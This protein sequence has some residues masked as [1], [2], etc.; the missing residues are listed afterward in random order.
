[1]CVSHTSSLATVRY[2]HRFPHTRIHKR[3]RARI[4]I[5]TWQG[6]DRQMMR[7]RGVAMRL[8]RPHDAFPR[9]HFLSGLNGLFVLT[10]FVFHKNR[11]DAYYLLCVVKACRLGLIVCETEKR[12]SR[13]FLFYSAGV[14][15]SRLY[16]V[17][18]FFFFRHSV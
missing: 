6:T 12:E 9:S 10:H 1:M 4:N 16:V 14:L 5:F 8:S 11:P 15:M 3:G 17:G 13:F 18:C 7:G 2:K